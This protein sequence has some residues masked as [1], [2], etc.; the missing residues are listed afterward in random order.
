VLFRS[1]SAYRP[2]IFR[3]SF[4]AIQGNYSIP[5]QNTTNIQE[6]STNNSNYVIIILI[7]IAAGI[8]F[9]YKK[10][11]KKKFSMKPGVL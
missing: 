3:T 11:K 8:G 4:L 9:S 6:G 1:D 2:D 10:F 7:A 5:A